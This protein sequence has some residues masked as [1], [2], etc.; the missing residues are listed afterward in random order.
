[1]AELSDL[2]IR[3]TA[4]LAV[5]G[6]VLRVNQDLQ[7]SRSILRRRTMARV[8]WTWGIVFLLAHVL[9][10]FHFVHGWDHARAVAD[11][12]ARTAAVVGWRW[13]GGVYVNH[14]F[15]LLWLID[16]MAWW[17]CGVEFPYRSRTYYW[18]TQFVFAF[19]MAN[20]TVVFGPWHW[21]FIA[22]LMIAWWIHT[23]YNNHQIAA[24]CSE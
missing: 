4:C 3:L 18:F 6:Y 5:V 14:L 20:A 17:Y 9:L 16:A 2:A 23:Y 7:T 8:S 21:R 1:M 15:A 10:G 12:A 24:N 22:P 13:G 19:I 11:T